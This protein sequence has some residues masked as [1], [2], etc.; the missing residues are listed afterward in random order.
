[1]LLGQV[2]RRGGDCGRDEGIAARASLRLQEAFDLGQERG[3]LAAG[4]TQVPLPLD[5]SSVSAA[6]NS[7]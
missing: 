3:I 7:S 1:M 4:L 6:S 5:A 2:A